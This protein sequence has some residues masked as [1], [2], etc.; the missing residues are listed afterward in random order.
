MLPKFS[1]NEIALY[2]EKLGE[3]EYNPDSDTTTTN[4]PAERIKGKKVER[5]QRFLW[6]A[7]QVDFTETIDQYFATQD[8]KSVP[9]DSKLWI[10]GYKNKGRSYNVREVKYVRNPLNGSLE[11][12]VLGLTDQGSKDRETWKENL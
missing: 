10:Q 2:S 1:F 3:S 12:V 11:Y 5:G 9:D 7:P 8:I 6:S 4:S